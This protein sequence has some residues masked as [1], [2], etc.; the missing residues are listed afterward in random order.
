MLLFQPDGITY[1]NKEKE[2]VLDAARKAGVLVESPCGGNGTCGKC[3]VKVLVGEVNAITEE[4]KHFFTE[5]ELQDG[6]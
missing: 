5:Q 6:W 2:T 4:E 1:I 3:R